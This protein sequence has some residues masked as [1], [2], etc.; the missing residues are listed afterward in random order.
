MVMANQ[1]CPWCKRSILSPR[2]LLTKDLRALRHTED[3]LPFLR[4][5][6]QSSASGALEGCGARL[7]AFMGSGAPVWEVD[8]S[9]VVLKPVVLREDDPLSRG[10]IHPKGE[11]SLRL[12]ELIE[13]NQREWERQFGRR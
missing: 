2:E 3:G 5:I 8:R 13:S 7:R 9:P 10:S 1:K 4:G 11:L 6:H 12:R